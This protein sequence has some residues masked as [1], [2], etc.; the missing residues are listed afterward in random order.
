MAWRGLG[1]MKIRLTSAAKKELTKVMAKKI[2]N[3]LPR[4]FI[5]GHG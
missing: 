4:I 2:G 3:S 1:K 5:A